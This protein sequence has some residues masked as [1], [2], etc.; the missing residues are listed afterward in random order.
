M[1]EINKLNTLLYTKLDE[2]VFERRPKVAPPI[3]LDAL[4]AAPTAPPIPGVGTPGTPPPAPKV[5]LAVT[6]PE[7]APPTQATKPPA[8]QPTQAELIKKKLEDTE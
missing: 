4:V 1:A 5:P 3:D 7:P 2:W 6:T 8:P